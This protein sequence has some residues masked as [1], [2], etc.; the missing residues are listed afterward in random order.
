M[1]FK[2]T[3]LLAGL[4]AAA[5]LSPAAHAQMAEGQAEPQAQP[6]APAA[7][8]GPVSD[9][10]VSK[11]AKV[12]MGIEDM[13]KK[14]PDMQP[15]QQQQAIMGLLQE[16]G[17]APERFQQIAMTS[18]TDTDLRTRIGKEVAAMNQDG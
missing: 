1:T 9:E 17:L 16:N 4:A 15:E 13:R 10:E 12:V 6:A 2:A 14:Q 5:T 11:F 8:A 18:R 7:D 3:H